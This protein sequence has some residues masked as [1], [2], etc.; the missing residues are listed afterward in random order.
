MKKVLFLA[1]Q[2]KLS[3]DLIAK[4]LISDE[5]DFETMVFQSELKLKE[6]VKRDHH[7]FIGCVIEAGLN[8]S[9]DTKTLILSNNQNCQIFETVSF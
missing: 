6:E 8:I 3:C 9:P 5:D 7:A 4:K 2:P 1:N